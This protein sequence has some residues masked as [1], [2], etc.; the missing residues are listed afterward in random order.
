[1]KKLT[2]TEFAETLRELEGNPLVA[3]KVETEELQLRFSHIYEGYTVKYMGID[4]RLND[5]PAWLGRCE[6]KHIDEDVMMHKDG[7]MK[8]T[9]YL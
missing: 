7:S 1:M 8:Y 4:G 6:I 9:I 2:V 5:V 3:V